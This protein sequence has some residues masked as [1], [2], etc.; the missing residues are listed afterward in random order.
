M[1][2]DAGA[3]W[4]FRAFVKTSGWIPPRTIGN[5][6]PGR[7]SG[8]IGR[9]VPNPRPVSPVHTSMDTI[10]QEGLR[11]LADAGTPPAVSLYLPTHRKGS[12]IRQDPIGM[13]NLLTEAEEKLVARGMR[14]TEARDL[15]EPAK[16]LLDDPAVW[17]PE[18]QDGLA[19]F[20][21]PG[22]F[23]AYHLPIAP[24]A[25]AIVNERFHV[26]PLLPILADHEFYIL[27][28]SQHDARLLHCTRTSCARVE[29][30]KDV[31]T[32]LDDAVVRTG[33]HPKNYKTDA[34]SDGGNASVQGNAVATHTNAPDPQNREAENLL[35]YLRQIDDGVRR[36]AP[37]NDALL[38]LAGDVNIT[39]PYHDA[40]K[41]KKRDIAADT[42]KGNPDHTADGD[43]HDK[44]VEI[45]NPL[46]HKAL[47]DEQETFGNALAQGK[48]SDNL[49]EIVAAAMDGRVNTLFVDPSEKR[50]G[51]VDEATRAVELHEGETPEGQDLVDWAVMRTFG[52][53]GR[54]LVVASEDVPGDGPLAAIM[55]Y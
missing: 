32:D 35:F 36:A 23:R 17:G 46:W 28:L 20:V 27:A 41:L 2:E 52:T 18:S 34:T 24:E 1:H 3:G 49:R 12:G 40:T 45:L 15:L 21:A 31:E 4:T 19:V 39:S 16:A 54:V 42:I 5:R 48:A 55:R 30:P 9:S 6:F 26:K 37:E 50:W 43:L 51:R 44:A 10:T 53:S 29:L 47:H 14:G 38:V 33:E 7:V 13:K 11:A 25:Q 22:T 8:V